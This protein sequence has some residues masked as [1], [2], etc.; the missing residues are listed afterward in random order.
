MISDPLGHV[1]NPAEREILDLHL[2]ERELYHRLYKE[3][4]PYANDGEW[5]QSEEFAELKVR[6]SATRRVLKNTIENRVRQAF[7]YALIGQRLQAETS[8]FNAVSELM[9]DVEIFRH[10]RSIPHLQG[11]ELDIWIPS[12]RLGI[13]YQGEQHYRPVASWGGQE[14]LRLVQERDE[15]KK[16][17][18][19]EANI[20]LVEFRFDEPIHRE[21]VRTKLSDFL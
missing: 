16:G 10:V 20:T 13:E 8:L 21:A 15:R 17:Y 1:V 12:K 5:G 9:P 19:I 14:G 7:G 4:D 3:K 2:M 11:L 18:C 6:H